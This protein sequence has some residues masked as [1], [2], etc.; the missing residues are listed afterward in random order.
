MIHIPITEDARH[1]KILE[2]SHYSKQVPAG[3]WKKEQIITR[4]CFKIN[5][6]VEGAFSIFA[7]GALHR[8]LCGDICVLPPMKMHYGQILKPMHINYYQ[9][10]VGTAALESVPDGTLLLSRLVDLTAQ[11]P[12]FLR[13]SPQKRETVMQLCEEIEGAIQK[14]VRYL[15]FA[16][17][18]EL[19]FV[20]CSLYLN[21]TA[22]NGTSISLR[23]AQAMEYIEKH[24]GQ[25]VT[26]TAMAH[27]L[28]VSASFLSRTFKKESG[29]TIHEYL[30]QYRIL[31]STEWLKDH[32]VS[33]S[34]YACGF[35][36]DSHFI[37]L[38]KKHLKQTPLQYK[39][40]H[41]SSV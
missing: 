36:D 16:K 28:G 37:S 29:F 10:D 11:S 38:F 41:Y 21:P 13:P 7:D 15:A 26:V 2:F 18:V 17:V 6:F 20:L 35:C 3:L 24:Y 27:A 30:N 5:V 22:P 31:R 40:T 34:A 25:N 32:S 33:E 39:K 1:D 9:L 19:L 12:S 8:P 23:T 14:N 4:D